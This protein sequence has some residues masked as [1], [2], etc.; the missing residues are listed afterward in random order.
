M[1]PAPTTSAAYSDSTN[2]L[3]KG[4][5]SLAEDGHIQEGIVAVYSAIGDLCVAG[6]FESCDRLLESIDVD[7]TDVDLLLSF[8]MATA[9]LRGILVH[10]GAFAARMRAKMMA[11]LGEEETNDILSHVD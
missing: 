10:R 8:Y 2:M 9:N 7:S 6:Q 3:L 11:E 4:L 5:T 1:T